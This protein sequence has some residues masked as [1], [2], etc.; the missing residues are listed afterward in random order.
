VLWDNAAVWEVFTWGIIALCDD[1]SLFG[2]A[3]AVLSC[4][5]FSRNCCGATAVKG[6]ATIRESS[7]AS[8]GPRP[9][10][11]SGIKLPRSYWFREAGP[12]TPSKE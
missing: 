9:D 6:G 11:D 12:A 8:F 10:S 7:D 5:S 3:A 2:G 4:A 1:I